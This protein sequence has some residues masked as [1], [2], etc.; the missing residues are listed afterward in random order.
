MLEFSSITTRSGEDSTSIT[1]TVVVNNFNSFI[2]RVSSDNNQNRTKDF[3]FVAFHISFDVIDNGWAN[4]VAFRILGML[5]VTTIN[6]D[7]S[8]FLFSIL[9]DSSDSL[10]KSFISEGSKIDTFI[11]TDGDGQFLCSLNHFGDPGLGITNKD[12]SGKSHTSLSGSTESSTS[13]SIQGVFLISIS[14]DNSVILG[15]HIGLDSLSIL[16]SSLPD[17]LTSL[18]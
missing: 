9:N 13:H 2:E 8:T 18:V 1:P 3:F 17:V 16:G 5:V 12:S 6:Q 7:F 10:M 4:K 14:Q 15:T 11:S